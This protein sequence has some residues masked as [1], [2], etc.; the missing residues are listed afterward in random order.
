MCQKIIIFLPGV[1]STCMARSLNL[2]KSNIQLRQT[3]SVHYSHWGIPDIGEFITLIKFKDIKCF[4]PFH[5]YNHYQA[6]FS[7]A[8]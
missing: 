4:L 3:K 2:L 1:Y 7:H 8:D 5:K 6:D